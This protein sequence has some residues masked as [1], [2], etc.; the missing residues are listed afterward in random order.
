MAG[1]PSKT[2]LN[3][4]IAD[5]TAHAPF[6][7][8]DR[9]LL[10]SLAAK[11][12]LCY[13]PKGS[14]IL[15]PGEGRVSRLFIVQ[16]GAVSGVGGAEMTGAA[17]DNS[18]TLVDGEMFPLGAL[19][20]QRATVLTFIAAK[21]TFCYKLDATE[22]EHVMDVSR[23]FRHFATRRLAHLLDQSRRDTQAK[24]GLRVAQTHS[25]AT[26]LRSLVRRAPIS[27]APTATIRDALS[28]MHRERIGS[29]VAVDDLLRPIGIFTERDVVD[30]VALA[31]IDQLRPIAD[32]MTPNPVV[33]SGQATIFEA[34]QIMAQRRFRHIVIV[35]DDK[36]AGVISERD[37]FSMQ[38][39]SLGGVAKAVDLAE[40]AD[41]LARA[42]A[43]VRSMTSTLIAQ[44][45]S[46]EQLTHF[47][48]TLN[49]AIV[50]R[51]LILA[52]RE[53]APPSTAWCWLGLGSEGRAEQTL[54]TDQD[55]AI[56]FASEGSD[57][58]SERA[59]YL[60][61]ARVANHILDR[62]GFPLCKGKIMAMNPKWC[63]S[64]SE[65]LA[66]FSEWLRAGNPQA[67]LNAAIFFDFRALHGDHSLAESL[68]KWLAQSVPNQPLFLRMMA[69]NALQVRPPL[70]MLRDFV[71]DD[72]PYPNTIDL[73]KFAA[74]PFVDVARIV[75]LR[76]GLS[77]SNTAERLRLAARHMRVAD[78]EVGAF[79]DAFHFVQLLRLRQNEEA[80]TFAAQG[81]ELADPS[82]EQSVDP[83]NPNRIW[84][85]RLNE[86]DRR[87]LKE[88]LRQARKLQAR[89]EMDYQL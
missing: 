19:I 9:A 20:S 30:R 50:G 76:H 43:D 6:D 7:Q 15:A 18:V 42:A 54:A 24:F 14:T 69:Q 61:F 16:R 21:D 45:V 26:S 23:P 72:S 12:T 71:D 70:G 10:E 56:I 47:V 40:D 78:E 49:D 53:H 74:R 52:A 44:G 67:L 8:M 65:W 25:L 75:A 58:E 73:K 81:A 17:T 4:T 28:L 34:A 77:T 51:A 29:I 87:I 46:A 35:D 57:I 86:L 1:Q 22:F 27:V 11:L 2:I 32:V 39:L 79:I 85:D 82:S 33:L 13:Y 66:T 64:A 88:A 3:G 59:Q 63:L 89:L 5:L 37:L 80:R 55:N 41:V 68:R 36:L 84:I 62:A 31:M 83:E 48:T 60:A 38:R